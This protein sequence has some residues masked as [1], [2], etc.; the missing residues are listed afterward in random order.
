MFVA[1]AFRA[2]QRR[3]VV[4]SKTA[5]SIAIEGQ[6]DEIERIPLE[7]VDFVGLFQDTGEEQ[8]DDLTEGAEKTLAASSNMMQ[9]ATDKEGEPLDISCKWI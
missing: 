3:R 7:T 1:L 8:T 6:D 4:L 2:W 5:L 9:I